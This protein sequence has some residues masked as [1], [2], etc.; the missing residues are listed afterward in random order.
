MIHTNA[1]TAKYECLE[2]MSHMSHHDTSAESVGN[3]GLNTEELCHISLEAAG[4]VLCCS[5]F[6]A[7]FF[8]S[9]LSVHRSAEAKQSLIPQSFKSIC[10]HRNGNIIVVVFPLHVC[11]TFMQ[12]IIVC[13]HLQYVCKLLY[14]NI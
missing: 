1:F 8:W 14:I 4:E 3:E 13:P 7:L 5:S 9:F 11:I 6:H 10:Y 2:L 12:C